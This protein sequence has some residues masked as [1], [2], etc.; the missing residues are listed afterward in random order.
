MGKYNKLNLLSEKF[1][2]GETGQEVEGITIMV[3]GKFKQALD[4]IMDNSDEYTSYTEIIRDIIFSGTQ[5]I[6]ESIKK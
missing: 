5:Q 3:D 1:V 6:V 2:N 4:I